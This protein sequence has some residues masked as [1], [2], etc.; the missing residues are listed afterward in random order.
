M[1]H[2]LIPLA[3]TLLSPGL[4]VA[5]PGQTGFCSDTP[6][7]P[8]TFYVSPEGDDTADGASPAT[9]WASAARVV[10]ATEDGALGPGTTV[11]F[12][13]GGTYAGPLDLSDL[14]GR[15]GVP[16]RI[17]AYCAGAD[18]VLSGLAR[19]DWA[20]LGGGGWRADCP[21]C[22]DALNL[23]VIDARPAPKARWP[24][25]DEAD[26]GYLPMRPR[27]GAR[28]AAPGLAGRDWT[29]AELVFRSFDWV[30]DVAPI[31]RQA[32][33]LIEL[34]ELP[35]PPDRAPAPFFVQNHPGALDADREWVW[36]AAARRLTLKL[37]RG[38]PASRGVAVA[39]EPALLLLWDATHIVI[40]DIRIRGAN[41]TG[42]VAGDCA[43]VALRNVRIEMS[44][45]AG[46]RAFDC[47]DMGL[48]T[49][50]VARALDVGL[51]MLDCESCAVT[52][53]AIAETALL[54]GMGGSGDGRYIA[55]RI[56]GVDGRGAPFAFTGNRVA[57]AGYIGVDIRG[58]ARVEGND[59]RGYTALKVDGAG[60]YTWERAGGVVI[61]GNTVRDGRGDEP[62]GLPGH[63][64]RDHGIYIDDNSHG[65][66]ILRN[67][68]RNAGDS[69]IKLH[70]AMDI[71]IRGNRVS[72][73]RRAALDLV[74]DE[75]A[76]PIAE[77]ALDVTGNSFDAGPSALLVD[78]FSLDPSFHLARLGRFARNA[79][80]GSA[81]GP[82]VAVNSDPFGAAPARWSFADWVAR[83]GLDRSSRLCGDR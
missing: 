6:A 28:F 3:V 68:L 17:G 43:G 44:G 76:A 33:A 47:R 83:T 53:S 1:R 67:E 34:E 7:D 22:P 40:E 66:E 29:G 69:G 39:V 59:I 51:E 20:P 16:I 18:P 45:G 27:G 8:A 58:P 81:S 80:C 19:L 36:D 79:Y 13:R 56:G 11:R 72:G 24:N 15:P 9:A 5:G 64:R 75:D 4:S 23:V 63:A 77:K 55:A 32:G 73:S 50:T 31:A 35:R 25:P 52:G 70:N 12:A 71:A 78:I 54:P 74:Y 30:L 62:G 10:A 46:L 26:G 38:H 14:H 21:M 49:V 41:D 37:D 65:I 82:H 42:A 57:D 48:D 60:I 61:A 2:I